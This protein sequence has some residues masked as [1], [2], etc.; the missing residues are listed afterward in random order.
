M[1]SLLYLF[2]GVLVG[3]FGFWIGRAIVGDDDYRDRDTLVIKQ[4]GIAGKIIMQP[5]TVRLHEGGQLKFENETDA[6][7][8]VNFST[9]R[10]GKRGPFTEKASETRGVFTIPAGL[11]DDR[12]VDVEGGSIF[13]S[14][15]DFDA[16]ANGKKI[17]PRVKIKSG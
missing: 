6:D 5:K 1:D 11:K 3:V 8:Q 15:W 7:V 14:N 17:D 13:P 10:R 12:H 9:T 4:K 16:I 2:G